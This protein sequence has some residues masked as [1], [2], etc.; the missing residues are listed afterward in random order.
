MQ[1]VPFFVV[2][3]GAIMKGYT[4]LEMTIVVAILAIGAAVAIPSITSPDHH[5]LDAAGALVAD[6]I[7]FAGEEARRTGMIHGIQ[8]DL[9]NSRIDVFRLD[10]IPDPNLKVFDVRHPISKQLYTVNIGAH[11]H[12]QV[13]IGAVGGVMQGACSD[14][15]SIG[16]DPGGV[17][18]CIEPLST[19]VRDPN[20]QLEFGTH[21]STIMVDS[22]TARV[23]IE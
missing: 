4:L 22:Y 5:K 7:R 13:A 20:I 17:T 1:N 12:Q 3:C 23:S 10:E 18:R 15:E 21:R 19:R 8:V 2:E 14:P 9:A 16:I 11:P 6:A